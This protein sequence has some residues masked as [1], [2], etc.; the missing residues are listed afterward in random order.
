MTGADFFE[1]S[2]PGRLDVMGGFADYS[3]SLVL[4]M[5]IARRTS[6]QLKLR[7]DYRCHITSKTSEGDVLSAEINYAELLSEG[8]SIHYG[9]AKD[10]LKNRTDSWS[11]YV[12]GCALVLQKEKKIT[13]TGADIEIYSDVP[14]G[15]GVSSSASLE[16][17]VMKALGN[18]FNIDFSGTELPVLAQRVENEIAGAPCG[19]MDQ[20][21]TYFGMRGK[22][23]P[24]LC[25]P[26]KVL[27]PIVVPKGIAF[28]GVDSGVRHA[29]SEASYGDVRAAAFMG[30][31]IIAKT[32]GLSDAEIKTAR[33]TGDRSRLPYQ[34]YLCNI[35]GEAFENK[36]RATL[37]EQMLGSDFIRSY[38]DT[39]DSLTTIAPDTNYA[40][41]ACTGHPIFENERVH[42][43]IQLLEKLHDRFDPEILNELGSLMYQAHQ[44]YSACG[45]GSSRTDEIIDMVRSGHYPNLGGA[46]ITGGG[47]GGTV[48]LLAIGEEGKASTEKLHRHLSKKYNASLALFQ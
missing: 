18:A 20:L 44:G 47:S 13:F 23:L 1:G 7:D 29:V 8:K 32:F 11:A 43:F 45:I 34:G 2:A 19:L 38:G 31:T 12:V 48:C 9:Y 27:E 5:P 26:D 10:L 4:Q 22:L 46:K 30:Y 25:Q 14:F 15:K 17:S 35:S 37:P 36:W 16:I 21:A 42:R 28:V 6:V 41:R 3:G 33:E 39:I 40:I 24:I